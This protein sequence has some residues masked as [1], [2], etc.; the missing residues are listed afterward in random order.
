MNA[1]EFFQK[2][3]GVWRSQRTTHHLAFKRSEMGGSEI[4][5]Q[6]LDQDEPRIASLCALH[7]IDHSLAIGGAYVK[8][9]GTMAWDKNDGEVHAGETVFALVPDDATGRTG[10]LLREKGYAE[11]VPVVG[12]YEMDEEDGLVLITEYESMWSRERFWF[13]DDNTRVRN[14]VVK[15]FGGFS[16]ATFCS[17][18][19]VASEGLDN[20]PPSVMQTEERT[21]SLFGW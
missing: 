21:P 4:L 14:S 5:V 19:R 9:E 2:S 3:S 18:T 15:R 6:A 17:E 7:Q 1:I 10:R 8:W 13:A 20:P 12:R 16:S 11:I